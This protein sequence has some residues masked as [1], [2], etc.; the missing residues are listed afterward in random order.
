MN[1]DVPLEA[2]EVVLSLLSIVTKRKYQS[3]LRVWWQYCS[4]TDSDF[5]K[6]TRISV[7][8]FLSKS[9][10][11]DA[12]YGTLN[13]YRSAISLISIDKIGE[14][15]MIARFLKGVYR[16]TKYMHTWEPAIVWNYLK[17]LYPLAEL[18]LKT[19]SIRR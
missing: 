10:K 19:V 8:K 5:Y 9:F 3:A 4:E 14:N 6:P 7:L 15:K 12:T 1:N 13:T 17:S 16:C 2:V 18:D 11:A